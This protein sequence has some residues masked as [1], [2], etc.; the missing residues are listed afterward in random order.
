MRQHPLDDLGCHGQL[1][2]QRLCSQRGQLVFVG[3]RFQPVD[4]IPSQT[5]AEVFTNRHGQRRTIACNDKG[6]RLRGGSRFAPPIVQ[7]EQAGLLC[8][9]KQMHI[10]DRNQARRVVAGFAM[11]QVLQ[12]VDGGAAIN[13]A[14][15]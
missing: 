8:V 14:R 11:R 1:T 10:I 2:V 5:R 4:Q 6:E 9:V 12:H 15:L 7:G 13:E 3:E